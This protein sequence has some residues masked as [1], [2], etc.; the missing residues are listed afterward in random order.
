MKI[1]TYLRRPLL[2]AIFAALPGLAIA[3]DPAPPTGPAAGEQ[4]PDDA[5]VESLGKAAERFVAAFNAKDAAT[6]AGLFLPEGEMIARDG[7]TYRG[8][9]AIEARYREIFEKD[10]DVP[11]VA[12][13]ASAVHLIAPGVAIEEGTVHFTTSE[14]EP[15]KSIRYSATQVKQADGTW[16]IA[17]TRDH[18][19]VTPPSERLKPLGG[20]VGEWT[21]ESGEGVRTDLAMDLDASGNFLLGE[22]VASDADGGVQNT[23]I[24]IGWNPATSSVFW[25][26]FDSDGGNAS[27]QWTRS[28]E[29]W[30]IR[31]SGVTADAETSAATQR[32]SFDGEDTLVWTSTDRVLD[33]E[34]QPDVEI[35]FVRRAPDPDAGPVA[36]TPEAPEGE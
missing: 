28:G 18:L 32:L 23:T 22:A 24:R 35:R 20:L 5:D 9:E 26:T 33:G 1:R 15:V 7:E 36:D 29:G 31:T 13:E 14:S 17:S 8:R 27:G 6:I 12:L 30:L 10:D 16:L 11:Q 21:Y 3:Q 2:A 4:S 19:E 25:W 34:T